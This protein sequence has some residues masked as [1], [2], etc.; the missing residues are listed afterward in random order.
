MVGSSC[1]L[2]VL[3]S[4]SALP[5]P[6]VKIFMLDPVTPLDVLEALVACVIIVDDDDDKAPDGVLVPLR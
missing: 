2:E 5:S 6:V 1:S 4:L 3:D